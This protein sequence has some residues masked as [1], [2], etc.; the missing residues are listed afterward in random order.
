[1]GRRSECAALDRRLDAVRRGESQA[2]VVHGEPGV[3]KTALLEDAIASAAGMRMA[4]VAGIESEMELA[5]AALQQLC[6]PMLDG[7]DRLPDPQREALGVVFGLRA[8]EAPDRFL[9]GL[10][11][12]SLLAGAANKQ[13]LLCVIDDA[14]WLDRASAQ[15]MG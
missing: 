15:A 12:L 9:V 4:R 10:A 8:G 5:Y 11:A 3:G 6:A 14:P 13:P 1:M 7:L 2:L